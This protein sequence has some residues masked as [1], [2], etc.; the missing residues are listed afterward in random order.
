[1]EAKD[2][3]RHAITVHQYDSQKYVCPICI[4]QEV[5]N[6]YILFIN[7]FKEINYKPK[8]N[9][10]LLSHLQKE[11]KDLNCVSPSNN[12]YQENSDPFTLENEIIPSLLTGKDGNFQVPAD[13][14]RRYIGIK[15]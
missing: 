7:M 2:F 12:L 14:G 10:N 9:T 11:H 8:H 5:N 4:L 13:I 15:K 1:M 6:S 3:Y